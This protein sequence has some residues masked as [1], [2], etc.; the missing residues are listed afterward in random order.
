[1]RVCACGDLVHKV[2]DGGARIDLTLLRLLELL[3]LPCGEAQVWRDSYI[4]RFTHE[5]ACVRTTPNVF[6]C[7]H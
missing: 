4:Y 1:M 3:I 6:M 2:C 7:V 5:C